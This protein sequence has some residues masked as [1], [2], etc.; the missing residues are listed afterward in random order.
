MGQPHRRTFGLAAGFGA[1]G[2]GGLGGGY[3][4]AAV[5]ADPRAGEAAGGF[6]LSPNNSAPI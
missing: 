4:A 6:V 1:I 5:D 3:R 2:A